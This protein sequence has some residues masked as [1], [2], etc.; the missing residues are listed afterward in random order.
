MRAVRVDDADASVGVAEGDEVFAEDAHADRH[1]VRAGQLL[2]EQR[3]QPEAAEQLA[4]RRAG[5]DR[6]RNSLSSLVSIVLK[7]SF[8]SSTFPGLAAQRRAR[9]S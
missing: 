1:A 8:L 4:H 3:G 9:S 2:D 7:A 6:V 5:A